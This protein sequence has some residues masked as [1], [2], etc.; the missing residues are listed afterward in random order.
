MSKNRRSRIL[1]SDFLNQLEQFSPARS[2]ESW[3]NVG[4]MVGDPATPLT[5]AIISIDLTEESVARAQ[6]LG[7][8]L[9]F[10]HHP[11]IFPKQKGWSSL[12]AVGKSKL[13]FECARAGLGYGFFADFPK[14][15][16]FK[17]FQ[18]RV[19]KT[20]ELD[21]F[22][23]TGNPNH[24]VKRVG[25]TPGKGSS[26]VNDA[27]RAGCDVFLTGETGYH[28]AREAHLDTGMRVIELGHPESEIYFLKTADKWL[29]SVKVPTRLLKSKVQSVITV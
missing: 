4:L 28:P 19:F 20:F 12:T 15:L 7:Y 23:L 13:L 22:T 17:E 10:N 1:L 16:S 29:K 27:A 11:A 24:K 2:A 21:R 3:D 9:I 26:F 8:N 25:F 6:A 14:E 5:G 18:S